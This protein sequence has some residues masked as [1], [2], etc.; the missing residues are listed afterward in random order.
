MTELAAGA[1]RDSQRRWPSWSSS[2]SRRSIFATVWATKR[3]YLAK[4][5]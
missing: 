2:W 5:P 4:P 3:A 1:S